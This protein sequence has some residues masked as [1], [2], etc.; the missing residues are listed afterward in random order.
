M[1]SSGLPL[2]ETPDVLIVGAGVIIPLLLLIFL[3][4]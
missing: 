1:Q 4:H 2:V 3:M